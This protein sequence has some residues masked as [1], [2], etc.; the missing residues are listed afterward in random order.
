MATQATIDEFLSHKKLAL[1][2]YSKQT[3]VQGV[4][5][6][7]ELNAK[8]YTVS[9]VY[10]NESDSAQQLSGLKSPV[11]GLI[12]AV[13]PEHAENAVRQAIDAKISRVWLQQ[14]AQSP[15]AVALCEK[16]N[17]SVISGECVLMFAAPVKSVHA[18]HRFIW[19][20]L[21]KMPK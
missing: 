6:D 18:F 7:R 11:E 4:P 9:V 19:K 21:G 14:G 15:A 2:R 12:V 1:M 8:G 17:I 10:L 3:P 5:M 13:N 16:N 20:L